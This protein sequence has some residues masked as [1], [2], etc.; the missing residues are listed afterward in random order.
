[1]TGHELAKL[2]GPLVGIG[3]RDRLRPLA[4]GATSDVILR[5][6]EVT[7]WGKMSALLIWMADDVQLYDGQEMFTLEIEESGD[8]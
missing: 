4:M 1:M 3:A 6:D 2:I 7:D 8:G 5:Y